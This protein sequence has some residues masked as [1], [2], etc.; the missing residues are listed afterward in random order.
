MPAKRELSHSAL[1]VTVDAVLAEGNT[2]M[3]RR[4]NERRLYKI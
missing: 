1:T 3:R 2:N 4:R